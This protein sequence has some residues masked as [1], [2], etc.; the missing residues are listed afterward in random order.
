MSWEEEYFLILNGVPYSKVRNIKA[1]RSTA[2][3]DWYIFDHVGGYACVWNHLDY[4][5]W[6][7]EDLLQAYLTDTIQDRYENANQLEFLYDTVY[8][9]LEEHY[10]E[11]V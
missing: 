5:N 8:R 7:Y 6:N 9:M 10:E 1:K 11:E 4:I 3:S 2:K